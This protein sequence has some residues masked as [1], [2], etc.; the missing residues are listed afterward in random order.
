MAFSNLLSPKRSTWPV[1]RSWA[2]IRN[3]FHGD[4]VI[5]RNRIV[6]L[7]PETHHNIAII[8]SLWRTKF[9][10]RKLRGGRKHVSLYRKGGLTPILVCV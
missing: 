4:Y 3:A 7:L 10:E 6:A 9:Y 8:M 5:R 2:V 1:Q